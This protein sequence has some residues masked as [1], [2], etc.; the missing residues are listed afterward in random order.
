M[1]CGDRGHILLSQRVADDLGT[2]HCVGLPTS[3]ICREVKHGVHVHL[4]NLTAMT[5]AIRTAG[6][7]PEDIETAVL[8]KVDVASDCNAHRTVLIIAGISMYN[9]QTKTLVDNPRASEKLRQLDQK[10]RWPT[11]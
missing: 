7:T 8:L 3:R 4:F 1:D 10:D 9:E 11:G 2:T 6:E 5:S